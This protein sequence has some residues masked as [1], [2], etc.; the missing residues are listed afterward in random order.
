MKELCNRLMAIDSGPDTHK[1]F[2]AIAFL[3]FIVESELLKKR[4][5]QILD[6]CVFLFLLFIIVIQQQLQLQ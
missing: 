1:D 3:W 4:K 2:G 5:I 6:F